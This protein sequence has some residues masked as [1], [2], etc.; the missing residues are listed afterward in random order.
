[1]SNSEEKNKELGVSSKEIIKDDKGKDKIRSNKNDVKNNNIVLIIIEI[2]LLI[3]L[4]LVVMNLLGI[5]SRLNQ[6][7]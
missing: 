2:L 6:L 1:M 3:V 7:I 4:I 5:P